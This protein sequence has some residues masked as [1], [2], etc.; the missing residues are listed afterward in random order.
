MSRPFAYNPGSPAPQGCTQIGDIAIGIDAYD[1]NSPNRP[2]GLQWWAGPDETI[3]YVI[4]IPV[5]SIDQPN[6]LGIPAGVGFWRSEQKTDQSFIELIS[7]VYNQNFNTGLEAKNWLNSN[8]LWT[9]YLDPAEN[10]YALKVGS[11][12]TILGNTASESQLIDYASCQ[13][14]NIIQ[15]YD[16]YTIFN[17]GTM[18]SQ[19][20]TFLTK[21][22]QNGLYPVAI[23]GSGRSGFDLVDEWENDSGRV[24]KFWGVNKENEFW[25]YGTPQGP[26][27]ETF[28][29]WIDS[30][31]YVRD[32]YPHWHRSAYIANPTGNWGLTESN[33]MIDASIDVLEVTNYNTGKPDVNWYAFKTNQL[34]PLASAAN[35][36]SKIQKFVP[37]WSSDNADSGGFFQSNGPAIKTSANIYDNDYA[38][39]SYSN[40][41]SLNKIGYSIF[42]YSTLKSNLPDC[43]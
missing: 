1:Y 32:T 36:V 11:F 13:G 18:R 28:A 24:N 26:E 14:F 12:T 42:M 22:Y 9:S 2:G 30:M 23:M 6:P 15:L 27:S 21:C 16:L 31:Q 17:S 25:W 10:Y 33:Q 8:G 19:L 43:P 38:G 34:T 40:K 35:S 37:L 5:P 41:S 20:D 3:G 29:D 39:L 4:A 7:K